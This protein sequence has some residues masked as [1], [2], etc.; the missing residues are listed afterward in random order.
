MAFRSA[1]QS[2]ASAPVPRANATPSAVD[3]DLR[4]LDLTSP[5]DA[6]K[7][8]RSPFARN[9]RMYAQETGDR[10]VSISNR[11]GSGRYLDALSE[12]LVA[13][14]QSVTN[15]ADA[16]IGITT[17]WKAMKFTATASG[18]LTRLD[19]RLKQ[20]GATGPL[21]VE[22]WTDNAGVPGTKIADTGILNSDIGTSPAYVATRFIESPQVTNATVYWIVVHMQDDGTGNYSWRTNTDSSLA[23]NSDTAGLSWT[24]AG[25]SLS[26]K[27]Y[28]S[29]TASILGITRYAP[30]TAAN[31]TLT[32]VGTAL[33]K[34]N[35]GTGVQTSIATG[36]SAS[37]TDYFFSEMD[38]KKFWVNGYDD[39]KYYDNTTVST[40][41]NTNLPKLRLQVAHKNRIFGVSAADPNKLVFSEDPGNADG[42]GNLWYN[43][44]LSTSFIYVPSPKAQDPITGLVVFQDNL[45]IFTRSSK[46]VLYGSDPGSFSL[47]QSTGKKGCHHQNGI[48]ADEN[49]IYFVGLDGLYRH[50]GSSDEKISDTGEYGVQPEY[51]SMADK[52]K[53]F[54]TKWK[55]I[56]RFYYGSANSAGNNRCLLWH[57]VFQEWFLDTDA[58]V[59]R[60]VVFTDG[61][62]PDAMIEASSNS[63]RV[64]YAETDYN[65]LGKAIDFRYYCNYDSF[66]NP[67]Q[68]KRIQKLFPM[69][70]GENGNY[71]VQ[72][73]VDVDLEDTPK[74]TDYLITTTG[75]KI[76]AF[77]IGDGTKLGIPTQFKPR[78]IQTSGYGYYWQ[79]R[80]QRKA[81]NNKVRFIGYVLATR[82]KRL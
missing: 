6:I 68:K 36:L 52:S 8:N 38:G 46:Y 13:S 69:I 42:L 63:T 67:A 5:Y 37:A 21:V 44:W 65:N 12:T 76:G 45:Y 26:Y 29:S 43:A 18:P 60:A 50:N 54:I 81:I 78:R 32:A 51:S 72:I 17:S 27:A 1:F 19:L 14:D 31:S 55:G 15:S 71:K 23:L 49:Y 40:I 9:F 28:I 62:D 16:L 3:L 56:V 57:T 74:F 41:T 35:D 30:E 10:R 70:E 82:G 39:L 24:A 58:F 59:S 53:V 7:K 20:N 47:R 66:G 2:R 75:A 48:Y 22:L 73:G 79:L 11:K 77:S 61:D 33:Y 4:G 64:T 34:G 25:Y 80:I